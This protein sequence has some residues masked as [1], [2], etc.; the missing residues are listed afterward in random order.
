MPV[1]YKEVCVANLTDFLRR[2]ENEVLRLTEKFNHCLTLLRYE[3]KA[4]RARNYQLAKKNVGLLIATLKQHRNLQEDV[5]FPFLVRH[6]PKKEP[7]IHFL[8]SDHQII[9]RYKMKLRKLLYKVSAKDEGVVE[10]G[11]IHETG[12]SL[13]NLLNHHIELEKE[14]INQAIRRY[15]GPDEKKDIKQKIMRWQKSRQN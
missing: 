9:K 1:N 6:V 7:V 5:I 4:S 10:R 14:N 15:L 12:V 11:K 3:G 2:K 13:S 8:R